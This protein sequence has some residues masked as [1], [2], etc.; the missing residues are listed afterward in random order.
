MQVRPHIVQ[1]ELFADFAFA[2]TFSVL[3]IGLFP[4]PQPAAGSVFEIQRTV[5]GIPLGE[6]VPVR[7]TKKAMLGSK[8]EW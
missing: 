2:Y 5:S 8:R 7:V 1:V 6:L 3:P 4:A